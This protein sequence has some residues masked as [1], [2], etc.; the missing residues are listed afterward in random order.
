MI[1]IGILTCFSLLSA[2]FITLSGFLWLWSREPVSQPKTQEEADVW[3]EY[4]AAVYVEGLAPPVSE[5]KQEIKE[6]IA[7]I[8]ARPTLPPLRR[9]EDR[10]S[11]NE[12]TSAEGKIKLQIKK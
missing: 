11:A 8:E 7:R 4:S 2:F 5:D 1:L 3:H 9:Y 6:R 12:I 10:R